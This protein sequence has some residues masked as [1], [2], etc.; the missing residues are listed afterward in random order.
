MRIEIG[1]EIGFILSSMFA[2]SRY[3]INIVKSINKS[4]PNPFYSSQSPNTYGLK[5]EST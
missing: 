3:S 4:H 1:I 2:L 5:H